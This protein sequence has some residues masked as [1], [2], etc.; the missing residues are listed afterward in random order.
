VIAQILAAWLWY[1]W[2]PLVAYLHVLRRVGSAAAVLEPKLYL[3]H[4][5]RAF[6]DL[7]LGRGE[8]AFALYALTA[9]LPIVLA[10]V[11]WRKPVALELRFAVMLLATVL[12]A[13][14]LTVYDLVILAPAMLWIADWLQSHRS[15][16]IAWLLYLAY[17]LPYAGPLA[18]WTHLQ[19]SVICFTAL[20]VS[21]GWKLWIHRAEPSVVQVAN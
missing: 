6:W 3:M 9:G 7:L 10:I 5:L 19:L 12:V 4:S 2:G 11:C 17:G 14:H 8:I 16:P 15:S 21:F 20:M 1:G 13:P 18:Q